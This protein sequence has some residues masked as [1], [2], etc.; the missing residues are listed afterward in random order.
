MSIK[1]L[2]SRQGFL[3]FFPFLPSTSQLASALAFISRSTSACTLVVA[4]DTCPSQ[5]RFVLMST[6]ARSKC[7]AIVCRMVCGLTLFVATD[8]MA[9]VL[10]YVG[11][12]LSQA[13]RDDEA[14][15]PLRECLSLREKVEP[16]PW[17]AFEAKSLLGE[18][19]LAQKKFTEPEP[20]LLQGHEGMRQRRWRLQSCERG[21]LSEASER[22]VHSCEA[23]GDAAKKHA[24]GAKS[25]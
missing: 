2:S 19:L 1:P 18:S 21:V 7:V 25:C 12:Y 11:H 23:T 9:T 10:S 5:A 15:P 17:K 13:Q 14:E 8:W 20:L 6:P 22:I 16:N 4:N 3:G 24:P